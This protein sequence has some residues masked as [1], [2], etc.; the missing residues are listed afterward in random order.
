MKHQITSWANVLSFLK[1]RKKMMMEEQ[2]INIY[3]LIFRRKDTH[4]SC[5]SWLHPVGAG[6]E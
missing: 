4:L 6:E 5:F 2:E 1:G 3:I